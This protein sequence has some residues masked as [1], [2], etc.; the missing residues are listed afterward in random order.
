ME[1]EDY[2]MVS[3]KIF[4]IFCRNLSIEN[5]TTGSYGTMSFN[6]IE[7]KNALFTYG[8]LGFFAISS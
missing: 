2:F 8:Y 7:V 5:Y 3:P 1:F 6:F 4:E